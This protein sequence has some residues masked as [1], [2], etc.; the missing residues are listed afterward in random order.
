MKLNYTKLSVLVLLLFSTICYGQENNEVAG[1]ESSEAVENE[2]LYGTNWKLLKME[3][4][5][6][7]KINIILYFEKATK[8]LKVIKQVSSEPVLKGTQLITTKNETVG[9]YQWSFLAEDTQFEG[10]NIKSIKYDYS[11]IVLKAEG[12]VFK[13]VEITEDS[14]VLGVIKAPKAIFGNS[15]FNVKKIFFRK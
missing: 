14:L 13:I 11:S 5:F 2:L 3:P 15:I 10:D 9:F 6:S 4:A 7:D 8:Q 1:K 12:Y